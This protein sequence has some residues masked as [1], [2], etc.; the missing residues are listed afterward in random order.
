MCLSLFHWERETSYRGEIE[1]ESIR[2]KR[3]KLLCGAARGERVEGRMSEDT[4][5]RGHVKE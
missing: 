5:R 1:G 2:K 4:E 3:N